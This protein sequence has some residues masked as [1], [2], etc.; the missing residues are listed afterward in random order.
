MATK[1]IFLDRDGTINVDH[2]FVYLTEAWEFCV[3]A[4]EAMKMLQEAGYTLTIITNQSGIAHGLYTEGQMQ[5]VH[6]YMKQELAK[7]GVTITAVGVCPHGQ[8]SMC[9][10]RK[11]KIGMAQQIEKQIG[12]IDYA[13]SW[14]IGDKIKDL[15]FGKNAKTRTALIRSTYWREAELKQEPDLIVDSLYEFAV[16]IQ[17]VV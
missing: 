17:N 14:T 7:T 9:D 16:A 3:Q 12:P 13:Q 6:E 11:P 8:D 2:G 1:V 10:C 4:P 5:A 15:E